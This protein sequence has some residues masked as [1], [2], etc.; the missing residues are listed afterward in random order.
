MIEL[1]LF[2]YCLNNPIMRYDPTGTTSIR[3]IEIDWNKKLNVI[4]SYGAKNCPLVS[5]SQLQEIGFADTSDN[6][7]YDLNFTLYRYGIMSSYQIAHFL[8]QCYAETGGKYLLEGGYKPA[9]QQ[10]AYRESLKYYPYYGAGYIQLTHE[11]NYL[12][13]SQHVGDPRIMEGPA[14]VAANYAWRASGWF[15]DTAG[16]NAGLA[17]GWS[18]YN[19]SQMVNCGN[20]TGSPNGWDDRQTAFNKTS[21]VFGL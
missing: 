5:A 14:Y 20:L 3:R 8:A 1:N 19:V 4:S 17:S 13:F 12:L 2:A 6:S 18:L 16:I 9:N 15:W 7:L 21:K 11:S 10:Q